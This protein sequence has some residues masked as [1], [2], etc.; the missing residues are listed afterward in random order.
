MIKEDASVHDTMRP[1]IEDGLIDYNVFGVLDW[2]FVQH[3][4]L[5]KFN[6]VGDES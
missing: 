2:R 6:R 1:K 3:N 4:S 5:E